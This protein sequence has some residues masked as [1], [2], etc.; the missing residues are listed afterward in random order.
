MQE[1]CAFNGAWGGVRQPKAFYVSSYFWDRATEVGIISKEE[2][3]TWKV[4]PHRLSEIGD[5]ACQ[6]SP[7]KLASLF[8]K[9]GAISC[10]QHTV[11]RWGCYAKDAI[12]TT[13]Q[14]RS[15]GGR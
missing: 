3:T 4:T 2:A 7:S 10:G 14:T 8:P 5:Q 11:N 12:R 13:Q 1:Q 15:S 9:V 6:S